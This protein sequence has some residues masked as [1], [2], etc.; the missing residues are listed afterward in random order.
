MGSGWPGWPG[1][2]GRTR[3]PTGRAGLGLDGGAGDHVAL[4]LLFGE[5]FALV[6]A[7]HA[8]RR[9]RSEVDE[10]QLLLARL[11]DLG[12]GGQRDTIDKGTP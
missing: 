7:A 10:A 12:L 6:G 9:V 11:L 5:L 4:G 1:C 3:T 2:T 8:A